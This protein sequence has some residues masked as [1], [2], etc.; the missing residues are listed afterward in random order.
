MKR[1]PVR[2]DQGGAL[3]VYSVD[4]VDE[5]AA[6]ACAPSVRGLLDCCALG[7]CTELGRGE[8]AVAGKTPI[9]SARYVSFLEALRMAKAV[10]LL[11]SISRIYLKDSCPLFFDLCG[12]SRRR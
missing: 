1:I 11:V 6:V 3:R 10:H 4:Q 5:S 12:S 7:L 8:M 2:R 9:G